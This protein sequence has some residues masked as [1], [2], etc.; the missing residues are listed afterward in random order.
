M[1]K[2]LTT[3]EAKTIQALWE[4]I[5][6]SEPDISTEQ[7]FARVEQLYNEGK[8]TKFWIDA[9]NIAEAMNPNNNKNATWKRC[10]ES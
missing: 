2:K 4:A 6:E 5:E 10:R 8:S 3:E 9:G 1:Y 7:L